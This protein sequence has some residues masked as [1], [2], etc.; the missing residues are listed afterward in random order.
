MGSDHYFSAAPAGPAQRR[1]LR[2]HLAGEQRDLVTAG[3]I[4]SPDRIDKGTAV[5]LADAPPPAPTGRLLDI[6]CGWG[7]MA[8]T[9]A[10][11]APHASV[12]AVDVNQ[13]AVELTRENARLLGLDNV[14]A[15]LPADI[16]DDVR[17]D[18]IWSNPPIRI[19]KNELHSILLLWLHRLVPGGT[20]WLVVQRNLGSD[21]LHRWMSSEFGDDFTI[22]RASSS[23]GFRLLRVRRAARA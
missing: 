5:L 17:F 21:S 9:M 11:R 10:L 2:V 23:Q 14:T 7:A 20:A 6:G 19:G 12:Y 1:P 22:T 15:C 13:R 18:T 4:F 3:G 8:L 16:D